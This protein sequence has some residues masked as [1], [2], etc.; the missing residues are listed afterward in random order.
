M[1]NGA[2]FDDAKPENVHAMVGFS[3]EYGRY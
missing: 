1:G 3:K 2:F